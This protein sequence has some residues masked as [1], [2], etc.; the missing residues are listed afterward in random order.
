MT[1]RPYDIITFDC[2]GTLIDWETGIAEAFRRAAA[3]GGLTL[4][5][6]R[7]LEVYHDVE[8]LAQSGAYRRYRD[9]LADVT[10]RCAERLGWTVPA[11]QTSFLVES[12]PTWM[13]FPD[14]NTALRRLCQ[15]G[16]RLGILSNI[17][18]DLLAQTLR[19]FPVG[20]HLIVT[21]EQVRSYKPA[22]AHF[23]AARE[24]IGSQP[25]LHAAQSYFH[26]IEP[27]G[28]HGIP[29]AW[30]NRT[31]AP[32]SGDAAAIIQVPTLQGLVEW[33]AGQGK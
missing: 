3:A 14:T 8:P 33:L 31:G 24:R 20:F 1:A 2:Y 23:S 19:H 12:L 25:W 32:V 28:R 6:G 15:A 21:A 27:C 26:D 11:G 10:A 16:Y 18:D 7:I 29:A 17:D 4:D 5:P 30:I 13:P 22:P 9:L